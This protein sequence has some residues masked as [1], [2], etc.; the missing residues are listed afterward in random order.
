[1][2]WLPK[3]VWSKSAIITCTVG[4]SQSGV[5]LEGTTMFVQGKLSDCCVSGYCCVITAL[6]GCHSWLI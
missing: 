4:A 2:K 6:T 1:M 5:S 3:V